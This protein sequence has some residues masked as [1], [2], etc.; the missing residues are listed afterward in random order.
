MAVKG[1]E[2]ACISELAFILTKDTVKQTIK[3]FI[4]LADLNR[5]R[6]TIVVCALF[7]SVIP[8]LI[9]ILYNLLTDIEGPNPFIMAAAF[10]VGAPTLIISILTYI[11]ADNNLKRKLAYTGLLVVFQISVLPA[12]WLT[13][14]IKLRIFLFNNQTELELIAN[15]ILDSKWTWEFATKY[16]SEKKLP[17]KLT[18]HIEEDQTILFYIS[19]IIDNCHGI[20]YSR[21][22]NE[23]TR[24]NC[25]QLI[26][27]KRI[28]G[29]WYEWG[30]T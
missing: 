6:K 13:N 14:D 11:I 3:D 18:G 1:S 16:T 25:G 23:A 7:L 5:T 15:S 26:N 17:I 2:G 29:Q 21:T 30:T 22:G 10:M 24:N 27:W 9:F 20:A 8:G 28:K 4:R 12:I 19:G